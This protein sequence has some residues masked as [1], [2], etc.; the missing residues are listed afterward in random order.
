MRS[1]IFKGAVLLWCALGWACPGD[2]GSPSGD[3]GQKDGGGRVGDGSKIADLPVKA[4]DPCLANQCGKNL[5]CLANLC[6][7]MC[8]PASSCN[9]KNPACSDKEACY[10]HTSFTGIC[11]SASGTHGKSCEHSF[12]LPGH[13]C[14]SLK[15]GPS[16]PLCLKLCKLGCPTAGSQCY[17][18]TNGCEFCYP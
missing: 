4:G 5:L 1:T 14:V 12:C 18:A 8:T 15:G 17:K 13:L 16:Y 10:Q 11:F 3:G 6:R 7:T 9:E 2:L